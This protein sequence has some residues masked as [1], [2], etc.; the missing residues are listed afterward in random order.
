MSEKEKKK[1][2]FIGES[3][4]KGGVRS[5]GTTASEMPKELQPK[6]KKPKK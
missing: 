2:K 3:V 4:R 6:P 5:Y 1:T